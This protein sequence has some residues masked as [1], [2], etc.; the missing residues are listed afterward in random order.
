M[1]NEFYRKITFSFLVWMVFWAVI[2]YCSLSVAD[3]K[4]KLFRTIAMAVAFSI[5]MP[6]SGKTFNIIKNKFFRNNQPQ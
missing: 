4:E 5:F 6:I 3:V 2:N 1:F